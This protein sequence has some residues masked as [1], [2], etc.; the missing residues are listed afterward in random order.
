MCRQPALASLRGALLQGITALH[1]FMREEGERDYNVT[2]LMHELPL[3]YSRL[4]LHHKILATSI[5]QSWW[6]R[7][8]SSL[9][10]GC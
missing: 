1:M 8:S 7:P 3:V 2:H 4:G 5:E 6:S 9:F 10:F